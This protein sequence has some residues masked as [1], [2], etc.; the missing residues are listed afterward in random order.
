MSISNEEKRKI[1]VLM[2]KLDDARNKAVHFLNKRQF[3]KAGLQF[4]LEARTSDE[5]S[6]LLNAI[7]MKDTVKKEQKL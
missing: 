2:Q 6:S 4:N 3:R 5:L 1:T 7:A